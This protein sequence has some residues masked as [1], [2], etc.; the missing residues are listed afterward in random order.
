VHFFIIS[1]LSFRAENNPD[2]IHGVTF[3]TNVWPD[4]KEHNLPYPYVREETCSLHSGHHHSLDPQHDVLRSS[5]FLLQ[6]IHEVPRAL[7]QRVGD[8]IH[9]FPLLVLQ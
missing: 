1:P 2:H 9:E 4:K 3:S 5:F 6:W 8:F 7:L